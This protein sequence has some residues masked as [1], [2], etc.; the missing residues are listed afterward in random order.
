MDRAQARGELAPVSEEAVL[1]Q[2]AGWKRRLVC[3]VVDSII[4]STMRAGVASYA[5]RATGFLAMLLAETVRI[6]AMPHPHPSL[7]CSPCNWT[8]RL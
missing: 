1:E 2:E 5:S 6:A 3:D 8:R 7:D 4:L